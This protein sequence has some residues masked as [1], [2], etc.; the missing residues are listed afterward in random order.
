MFPQ[1]NPTY[2]L[3]VC[4]HS[5]GAGTA[6]L[7]TMKLR[8]EGLAGAECFA[9]ACPACVTRNLAEGRSRRPCILQSFHWTPMSLA[10]AIVYVLLRSMVYL[11]IS[12]PF[13]G[14]SRLSFPSVSDSV[15][16]FLEARPYVHTFVLRDD[17]IPRCS[18]HN[19]DELR[20][21][22]CPCGSFVCPRN[23][24]D[25]EASATTKF[26]VLSGGSLFLL[27]SSPTT[28]DC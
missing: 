12:A 17:I 4:G 21:E 3:V 25:T 10:F 16:P 23:L 24:K 20:T 5:L 19:L 15:T 18:F 27:L 8:A 26:V 9:Y 22:V 1:K 2:K 14:P 28:D 13:I 11:R 7:L 6:A